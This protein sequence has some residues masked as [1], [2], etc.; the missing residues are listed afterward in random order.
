MLD[1]LNRL[2]PEIEKLQINLQALDRTIGVYD[3]RI[4]ASAIRPVNGWQGAYGERGALKS[5]LIGCLRAAAPQALRTP[6]LEQRAI[7]H[8][9]LRFDSPAFHRA[10]EHK[11]TA[12]RSEGSGAEWP[13]RTG[14]NVPCHSR[15]ILALEAAAGPFVGGPSGLV[16]GGPGDDSLK[17]T[18]SALKWL[19]EQRGRLAYD[20]QQAQ[21]IALDVNTRLATL[22]VDLAAVDRQFATTTNTPTRAHRTG[23]RPSLRPARRAPGLHRQRAE[24]TCARVG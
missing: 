11:L 8:F 10:L 21:R 12:R 24:K 15:S 22:Q 16:A 4:E 17:K 23:E 3:L 20:L 9:S 1:A 6:E 5:F 19:A 13:S 14:R 18:P 7:G 2:P